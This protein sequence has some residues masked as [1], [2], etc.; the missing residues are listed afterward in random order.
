MLGPNC[1]DDDCHNDDGG[2]WQ[3][4]DDDELTNGNTRGVHV[5]LFIWSGQA[6]LNHDI[7]SLNKIIM[8]ICKYI[9]WAGK[10]EQNNYKIIIYDYND[11]IW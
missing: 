2:C 8:I 10:P 3:D 4:D 7:K 1:L 11:I 6:S 5:K 9:I